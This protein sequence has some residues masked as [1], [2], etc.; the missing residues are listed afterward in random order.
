MMIIPKKKIYHRKQY[1]FIERCCRANIVKLS[2]HVSHYN[3]FLTYILMFL[4]L[5]NALII[6]MYIL[7]RWWFFILYST[8]G[9]RYGQS[10]HTIRHVS[11]TAMRTWQFN[12][13]NCTLI[14]SIR[15]L[16]YLSNSDIWLSNWC[17][18]TVEDWVSVDKIV[19][20]VVFLNCGISMH[21]YLVLPTFPD[22][23]DYGC[24]VQPHKFW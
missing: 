21:K 13:R 10:R 17:L 19:L 4:I 22:D 7:Q 16:L 2:L 12:D 14:H 9:F 18:V 11:L 6:L 3:G 15:L 8:S 24:H 1:K 23:L 20:L 5:M